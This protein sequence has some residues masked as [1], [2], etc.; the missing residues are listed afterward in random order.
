MGKK[1]R[2]QQQ[3]QQKQQAATAGMPP[4]MDPALIKAYTSGRKIGV[5]QGHEEGIK[6]GRVQGAAELMVLFNKWVQE[7]E[8][9]VKGIGPKTKLDIE[10][11]FGNR[12]K[13]SVEEKRITS[14]KITIEDVDQHKKAINV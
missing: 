1:K 3:R 12:I 11:Y 2:L 5:M 13:E 14:A 6:E 4:K 8:Q 9:H 10:T 7:I